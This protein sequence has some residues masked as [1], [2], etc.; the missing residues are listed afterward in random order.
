MDTEG[1]EV[2]VLNA[3]LPR[4]GCIHNLVVETSPGWWAERYNINRAKGA[5]LYA[6]L[7]HEH[8]FTRAYTSKGRWIASAQEMHAYIHSFGG[9]GYWHQDDVWLT[10][11]AS[12]ML[13]AVRAQFNRAP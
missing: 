4:L 6:S 1:A 8:G 3:L 12:L 13:R 2:H 10:K 9:S 7:F 11:N 5:A